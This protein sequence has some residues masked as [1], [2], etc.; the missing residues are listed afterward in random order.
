MSI[1]QRTYVDSTPALSGSHTRRTTKNHETTQSHPA[2]EEKQTHRQSYKPRPSIVMSSNCSGMKRSMPCVDLNSMASQNDIRRSFPCHDG[3]SD[4]KSKNL[5]RKERRLPPVNYMASQN[6]T[7]K[8]FPSL[9]GYWD[10]KSENLTPKKRRLS[11]LETKRSPVNP[12][13]EALDHFLRMSVDDLIPAFFDLEE[14]FPIKFHMTTSLSISQPPPT[15][16]AVQTHTM[17]TV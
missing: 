7:R 4:I 1:R 16:Q 11:P 2:C 6:D 5:A 9:D 10:D 14:D 12:A 13:T 17:L 3:H 8:P 15:C